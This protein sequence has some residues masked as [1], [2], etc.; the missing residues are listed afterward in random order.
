[1]PDNGPYH[2][3]MDL[4][5]ATLVLLSE[6]GGHPALTS[7]ARTVYEQLARGEEAGYRQLDELI[8]EASGT[9]ALRA[10]RAR[11]SPLAYNAVLLP[12]LTELDRL[13]PVPPRRRTA[14]DTDPERDPLLADSWPPR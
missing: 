4:K 6:S 13:K 7:V 14:G 8:G 3:G 2:D 10:L 11:Y 9:G 12:I 5:D 1:M